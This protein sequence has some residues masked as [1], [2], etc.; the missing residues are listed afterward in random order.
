MAILT[1]EQ[2][3]NFDTTLPAQYDQIGDNS[4]LN[5]QPLQLDDEGNLKVNING[6]ITTANITAL[7]EDAGIKQVTC[8]QL[9]QLDLGGTQTN[10]L[11]D[12]DSFARSGEYD[13]IGDA[14]T[15]VIGLRTDLWQDMFNAGYKRAYAISVNVF[16]NGLKFYV[17][18]SASGY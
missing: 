4:I 1:D 14:N 2:K 9:G 5:P 7:N 11:R 6:G 15:A 16:S 13:N 8:D 18:V 3:L 17:I 12:G 10:L